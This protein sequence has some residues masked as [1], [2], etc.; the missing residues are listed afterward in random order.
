MNESEILEIC[1][2]YAKIKHDNKY[3]APEQILAVAMVT[4]KPKI[5]VISYVEIHWSFDGF[6]F[7]D[8][9]GSRYHYQTSPLGSASSSNKYRL[10]GFYFDTD[11][12][13]FEKATPTFPNSEITMGKGNYLYHKATHAVWEKIKK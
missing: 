11:G 7:K 4:R 6:T 2:E 9:E 8:P 5:N 13:T 1:A 12:I 10:V 3:W